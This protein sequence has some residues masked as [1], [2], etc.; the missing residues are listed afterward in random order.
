MIRR[1]PN[2]TRTATLFPYTTLARAAGVAGRSRPQA[3]TLF[4]RQSD[5]RRADRAVDWPDHEL[6]TARRRK[7]AT[8]GGQRID[9]R[10]N[11]GHAGRLNASIETSP[12]LRT[13]KME[14]GRTDPLS[15]C[16]DGRGASRGGGG[17]EV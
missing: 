4:S 9:A 6:A 17:T 1:P 11:S 8:D 7:S 3:A 15:F 16:E 5:R 10:T 14:R 2:S 13:R 12:S